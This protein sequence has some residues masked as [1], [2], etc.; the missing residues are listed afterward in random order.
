MN[1]YK[2]AKSKGGNI[3]VSANNLWSKVWKLEEVYQDLV[4]GKLS[5][6]SNPLP[7]VQKS[8]G[9]KGAV[10][11]MD[12]HHRLIEDMIKGVK[13]FNVYWEPYAL[14]VDAG[15][16]NELPEDRIKLVDFLNTKDLSKIHELV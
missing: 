16:G 9:L 10:F 14:Y 4:N 3:T 11:V 1:W 13:Q 5:Y 2:I 6:R 15:I 7:I 8:L 12:G